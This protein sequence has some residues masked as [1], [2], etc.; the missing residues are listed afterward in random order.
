MLTDILGLYKVSRICSHDGKQQCF[1]L[2]QPPAASA[3]IPPK[4]HEVSENFNLQPTGESPGTALRRSGVLLVLSQSKD[5][6]LQLQSFT[7]PAGRETKRCNRELGNK[8]LLL[9]E[10]RLKLI[11][12]KSRRFCPA[13][14]SEASAA[15]SKEGCRNLAL[16]GYSR[17][18]SI[19]RSKASSK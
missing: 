12:N 3:H 4:I 17:G 5:D 10:N 7:P 2:R 6:A 14:C 18:Q 9:M 16:Q 15:G 11:Q 19:A 13:S 1:C 8:I